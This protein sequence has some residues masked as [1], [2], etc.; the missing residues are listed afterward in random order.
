MAE[1]AVNR[2]VITDHP[3]LHHPAETVA[4]ARARRVAVN[5]LDATGR[6]DL[7]LREARSRPR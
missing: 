2:R 7:G 6:P 1:A 3:G 5:R 4:P